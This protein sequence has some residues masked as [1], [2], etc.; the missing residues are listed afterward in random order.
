MSASGLTENRAGVRLKTAILTTDIHENR[1]LNLFSLKQVLEFIF[2][3]TDTWIYIQENRYLNLYSF[4]TLKFQNTSFQEINQNHENKNLIYISSR[5]VAGT[6]ANKVVQLD[7]RE[8]SKILSIYK[9]HSRPVLKVKITSE[10][11]LSLSEDSTLV[12]YD[13]VAGK[14]MMRV[15]L[16]RSHP[17]LEHPGPSFPLSMDLLDNM[18]Y[19]GDRFLYYDCRSTI[20]WKLLIK[21]SKFQNFENIRFGFIKLYNIFIF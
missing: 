5:I 3:K 13:R 19:I 16:P 11:I 4:I 10:R 17:S 1:Y 20:S 21:L 15:E 12:V 8:E 18:L 2:M 9:S 14:K 6:F 7:A